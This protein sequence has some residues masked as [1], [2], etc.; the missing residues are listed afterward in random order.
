[1]SLVIILGKLFSP[2][3]ATP[4]FSTHFIIVVVVKQSSLIYKSDKLL[5]GEFQAANKM[6]DWP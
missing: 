3:T 2:L 1:M 5:R 4:S 6:P